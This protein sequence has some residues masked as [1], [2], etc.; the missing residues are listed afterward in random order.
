[1]ICTK[2]KRIFC[3][4]LVL[5]ILASTISPVFAD[6]RD[7]GDT[8]VYITATGTKYHRGSCGYL[9]S[10]YELTLREAVTRG[11]TPCSRCAPPRFNGTLEN[12][13]TEQAEVRQSSSEPAAQKNQ[14]EKVE[15][16]KGN[17]SSKGS[18]SKS[19]GSGTKTSTTKKISEPGTVSSQKLTASKVVEKIGDYIGIVFLVGFLLFKLGSFIWGV[20]DD[21]RRTKR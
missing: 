1:M 15:V 2:N 10:R 14:A 11:Y 16:V 4:V 5:L 13:T 17:T 21:A 18:G 20:I 12:K 3:I 8:I 7:N 19:S 9:R 6:T